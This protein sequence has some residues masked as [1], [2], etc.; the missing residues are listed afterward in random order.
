MVHSR[1]ANLRAP[2]QILK[3]MLKQSGQSDYEVVERYVDD[4]RV[5][6]AAT[7]AAPFRGGMLLG[8]SKD[9]R[10]LVMICRDAV[11]SQPH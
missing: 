4:G 10:D 1:D 7:V 2:T 9:K 5:I 3:V 11:D 8:P 6:N